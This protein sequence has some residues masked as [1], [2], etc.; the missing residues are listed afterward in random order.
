MVIL[1]LG[2]LSISIAEHNMVNAAC[3]IITI[4]ISIFLGALE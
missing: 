2:A 4:L 1:N 3:F